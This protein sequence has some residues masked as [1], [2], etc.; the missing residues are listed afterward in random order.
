MPGNLARWDNLFTL[1]G[2]VE[3]LMR[4]DPALAGDE[5]PAAP[6]GRACEA[7]HP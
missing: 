6:R 2:P 4:F 7:N 5:G 1:S 3:D